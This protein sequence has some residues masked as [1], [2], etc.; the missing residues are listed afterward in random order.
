M[1]TIDHQTSSKAL[2]EKKIQAINIGLDIFTSALINNNIEF[3]HVNWQP[4]GRGNQKIID[5]LKKIS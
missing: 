3:I 5:A 4:P 2:I 1:K